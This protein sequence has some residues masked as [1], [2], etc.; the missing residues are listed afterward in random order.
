MQDK[1]I[2]AQLLKLPG[3]IEFR[4]R[5]RTE[6]KLL[7]ISISWRSLWVEPWHS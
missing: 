2:R 4:R 1:G 6:Y 7:H 5:H 3:S